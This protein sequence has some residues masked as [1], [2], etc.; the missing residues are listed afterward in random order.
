MTEFDTSSQTN[1]EEIAASSNGEPFL[2]P[3]GPK[4]KDSFSDQNRIYSRD[5]QTRERDCTLPQILQ[6]PLTISGIQ[7]DWLFACIHGVIKLRSFIISAS[8]GQSWIE[9]FNSNPQYEGLDIFELTVK[10]YKTEYQDTTIQDGQMDYLCAFA[11]NASHQ[12]D[13]YF[14]YLESRYFS[15][16]PS[17]CPG[18]PDEWE[19]WNWQQSVIMSGWTDKETLEAVVDWNTEGRHQ[20]GVDFQTDDVLS[21]KIFGADSTKYVNLANNIFKRESTNSGDLKLI[22]DFIRSNPN[23]SAFEATWFAVFTWYKVA[24]SSPYRTY[25]QRNFLQWFNS[26]QLILACDNTSSIGSNSTHCFAIYDYFQLQSEPDQSRPFGVYWKGHAG[27]PV[28]D[29]FQSPQVI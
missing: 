25:E 13:L 16:F 5:S 6:A 18:V 11:Q 4:H 12:D 27:K 28:C 7:F 21:Q 20:A 23:N 17:I 24:S 26:F 15:S 8:R 1:D 9:S 22:T 19:K 29:A 2:L 3:F 14:Q 10:V